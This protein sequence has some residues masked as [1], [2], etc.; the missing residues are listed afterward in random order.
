[1]ENIVSKGTGM[2]TGLALKISNGKFILVDTSADGRFA[3]DVQ[4]WNSAVGLNTTTIKK[5]KDA[6]K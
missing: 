1:M 3:T 5:R 4:Q 2:I 6:K